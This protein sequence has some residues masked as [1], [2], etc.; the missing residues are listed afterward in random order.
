MLYEIR[1]QVDF[2]AVLQESP[3]LDRSDKWDSAM[4]RVRKLKYVDEAWIDHTCIIS[5]STETGNARVADKRINDV[6]T[7]AT[8]I[9]HSYG[10]EES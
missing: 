9:I 1:A 3:L 10:K 2:L 4:D 5:V 7:K 8:R 6:I